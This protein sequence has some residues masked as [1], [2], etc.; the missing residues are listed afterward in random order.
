MNVKCITIEGENAIIAA[1]EFDWLCRQ[2]KRAEMLE[3]AACDVVKW[4]WSGNDDDCVAD[5]DRLR[6]VIDAT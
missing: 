4:D 2:A 3:R 1:A 6:N 5:I